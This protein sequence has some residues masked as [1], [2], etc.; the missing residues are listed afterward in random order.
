VPR[1]LLAA[2]YAQQGKTGAAA[3]QYEEIISLQPNA[4]RAYA[5]LAALYPDDPSMR[6]SIYQ[7]GIDAN[8]QDPALNLLLAG[9]YERADQAE[10][11]VGIYENILA[12]DANNALAANNLAAL[13]LDYRSDAESHARALEL[14]KQFENSDQPALL[15]TLGWAY[16]R[17]GDYENAIRL[18]EAAVAGDDKVGLLHYHLGMAFVKAGMAERG[19][20]ALEQSLSLATGKFPGID[21]ARA[22]LETL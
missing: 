15:D 9:E 12:N 4:T 7:R 19:R 8:P 2:V 16:Y 22:T 1:L 13:L 11:A 5:S 20:E 18:L 21:E 6:R 3:E 14:A 17:T 10:N